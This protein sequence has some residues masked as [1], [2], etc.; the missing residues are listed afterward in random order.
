[1]KG[2]PEHLGKALTYRLVQH[3]TS[4]KHKLDRNPAETLA[5][6]VPIQ[7]TSSNCRP[8]PEVPPELA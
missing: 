2:G 4:D 6:A 5:E 1:M 3:L 7:Y 8:W